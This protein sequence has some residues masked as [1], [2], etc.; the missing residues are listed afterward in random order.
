MSHE[1]SSLSGFG[2]VREYPVDLAA[3][4]LAAVLSYAIAISFGTGSLLRFAAAFPLLL[5]LPGYALVAVLFP[6]TERSARETTSTTIETYPRGIDGIERAGLSVALSLTVVALVGLALPLTGWGLSA[7]AFAAVIAGFTV[8]SAQL[9]VVRRLRTPT[10]ERLTVS[11][12][13][14][15]TGLERDDTAVASLSTIVLVLAIGMAA[16]ALLL[17]FIAPTSGGEFTEL[18]LY[19]EDD[20]G[21]LVAGE[22]DNEVAAGQSIPV[23]VSIDNQEGEET[24]YTVVVQEQTVED[25]AVTE[26][27]THDTLETTLPDGTAGTG[28]LSVT[29]AAD[30]GET[31]RISVLLYEGEPPSEPTNDDAMEDTYFWVTV[32]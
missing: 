29:P 6:A 25:G 7:T 23:T 18:A 1:T 21:T 5:F 19:G 17:G 31:V 15:I 8:V 14:A 9:G 26:R 16:S 20:D 13:A 12:I 24:D 27:T 4:T 32:E 30:S 10:S 22:I 28:N 3:I 11:P 2:V